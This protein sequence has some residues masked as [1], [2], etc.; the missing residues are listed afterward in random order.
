M[1]AADGPVLGIDIGGTKILAAVVAGDGT[2]GPPARVA[3]PAGDGPA[4]VLDAAIGAARSALAQQPG[5]VTACGVGTAGTVGPGGVISYAT[6][7]LPGWAGTDVRAAVSRAL[8]LPAVVLNDVHAAALGESAHGAAAGHRTAL[9]MWIGTGIGG[10]IVRDGQV[11]RGR[12]DSAGGVG[13]VPVPD[14]TVS[15]DWQRCS[16]GAW[17]H[18]E[19]HASGPAIT[20]RYRQLAA[21]GNPAS[22]MREQPDLPEIAALAR[23]GDH[24]ALRVIEHAG[25]MIGGVLGGLV[26]VLDPDVIVLGGGVSSF[27]GLLDKP[28]DQALKEQALPGPASVGIAFSALG[29]LAVVIGAAAAARS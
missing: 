5:D 13:H 4:A 15:G 28:I 27:A 22:G 16:C 7:T 17:D 1:T 8:G 18:L 6:D 29:P 11:I 10:A 20:R 3:T 21:G 24:L 12:T 26:N 23:S 19:A 25:A 2:T 14:R 9:I